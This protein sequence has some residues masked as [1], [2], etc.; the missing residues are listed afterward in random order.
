MG[1][2]SQEAGTHLVLFTCGSRCDP[3]QATFPSGPLCLPLSIGG[4]EKR[5]QLYEGGALCSHVAELQE[6]KSPKRQLK[7]GR[8]RI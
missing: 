6:A 2:S 1:R 4:V 3:G 7:R 5:N 8:G